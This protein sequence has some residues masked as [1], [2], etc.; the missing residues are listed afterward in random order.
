MTIRNLFVAFAALMLSTLCGFAVAEWPER[1]ITVVVPYPPG[2]GLDI[3]ARQMAP[4]LSNSL[5]QVVVVE[6]RPGAT[7]SIGANAVAKASPDGYLLLWSSL[8]SH[9]IHGALYGAAVPYDLVKNFSPV[10]VFGGIPLVFVVNPSVQATTLGEFIALAKSR[11]GALAYASGGNGAV[12]HS[13]VYSAYFGSYS[14]SICCL[15]KHSVC[16]A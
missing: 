10:V 16:S 13:G 11:P 1:A 12:Q 6:N 15:E 7:G 5:G 2:G 14:H 3:T 8:T 4:L 9:S